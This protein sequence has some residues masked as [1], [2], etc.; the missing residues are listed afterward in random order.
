MKKL[1]HYIMYYYGWPCPF[2]GDDDMC[3]EKEIQ[4]RNWPECLTDPI[5]REACEQ[6]IRFAFFDVAEG[7]EE[8]V[9]LSKTYFVGKSL[10]G[11]KKVDFGN[12]RAL[13]ISDENIKNIEIV[14]PSFI[15]EYKA[16]T[17]TVQE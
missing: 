8:M 11:G 10:D 17:S 2:T 7:S 1:K 6:A 12:G 15:K 14:S 13:P 16:E 9:N 4:N 5:V 3:A